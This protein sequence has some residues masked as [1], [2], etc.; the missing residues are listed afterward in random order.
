MIDVSKYMTQVGQRA[1]AASRA[2]SRA[3]TAAK[4]AALNAIADAIGARVF[5]L[6]VTPEKILRALKK[7]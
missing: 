5:D 2:I 4:D 3:D 1:R 7:I 6:P